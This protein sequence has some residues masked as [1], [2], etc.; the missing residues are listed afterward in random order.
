M[1]CHPPSGNRDPVLVSLQFSVLISD[2]SDQTLDFMLQGS[3][4]RRVGGNLR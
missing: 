1:I 4:F 2:V 3:R